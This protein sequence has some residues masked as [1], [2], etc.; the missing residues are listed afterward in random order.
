ME[1][2]FRRVPEN[3][4]LIKEVENTDLVVVLP[5]EVITTQQGFLQGHGTYLDNGMLIASCCGIVD[6]VNKLISV[7]PLKSRYLG[8][9]GDIVV[10]RITEVAAKRWL[11][12]INACQMATLGLSSIILPGAEQRMK[13]SMDQLNMRQ[14]YIEH[15]LICAEVQ[16]VR[17]DG[18]IS[19]QTRS[20]KYGKLENGTFMSV[21]PA[22]VKR[23]SQHSLT[24]DCG[25]DI[26][27]GNNGY[28]WITDKIDYGYD[29]TDSEASRP[30]VTVME[31]NKQK[32]GQNAIESP[33]RV[34][35]AKVVQ[36]ITYL[37]N[38]FISISP[39]SIMAIYNKM[40]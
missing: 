38:H 8:E 14:F 11:V 13:N 30:L 12:D 25:I 36:A 4:D 22:L 29:Q 35:I 39:S 27:L 24:L 40:N 19:L 16:S 1:V 10:G 5:G 15:D 34:K 20:I 32:H 23:L 28:I 17:Q 6:R 9:I 3:D 21:P 31:S 18:S 2:A 37:K 33:S 7:K 26:I